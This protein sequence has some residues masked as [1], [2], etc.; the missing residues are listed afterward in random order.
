MKKIIALVLLSTL[1]FCFSGCDAYD[2][3]KKKNF[4]AGGFACK[5]LSDGTLA[6]G[7]VSNSSGFVVGD[8][9]FIPYEINGYTVTKLGFHSGMGFGGNGELST[10][11]RRIYVPNTIKSVG[12]NNTYYTAGEVGYK[13]FY[14]GTVMNLFKVCAFGNFYVPYQE[15]EKFTQTISKDKKISAANVGYYLNY[16]ENTYYYID[17]YENGKN[18]EYIPPIPTR[19]G[20]TFDGWFKESNCVNQWDFDVDIVQTNEI[21]DEVKLY[22]KWIVN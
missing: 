9:L 22:A 4:W 13:I 21:K 19:S 10:S 6:V 8:A 18:I 12:S 7:D 14:C 5:V 11:F 3:Y 15:Q 16:G 2:E 20:Y 17:Y 1:L